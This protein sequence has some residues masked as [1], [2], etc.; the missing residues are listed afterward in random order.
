MKFKIILSTLILIFITGCAENKDQSGNLNFDAAHNSQNSLDWAGIYKG[1]LPCADCSGI[2][3]E[4]RLN[5]N[6]SFIIKSKYL[7]KDENVFTESGT[8]QFDSSGSIIILDNVKNRPD[9]FAV[10]ENSLTQLDLNGN[11]IEGALSERYI[12]KK[13]EEVKNGNFTK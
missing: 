3:T 10:G 7:G 13:I 1:I 4:I 11:K 12:L 8:F 6:Y 9:K 5:G 2:E